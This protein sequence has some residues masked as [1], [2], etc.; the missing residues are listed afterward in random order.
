MVN[1]VK[2]IKLQD[3]IKQGLQKGIQACG[4]QSALEIKKQLEKE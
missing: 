1:I 3:E 4:E 2:Y